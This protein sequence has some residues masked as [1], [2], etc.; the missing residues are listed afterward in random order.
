MPFNFYDVHR[1]QHKLFLD[2]KDNSWKIW[3]LFLACERSI[4]DLT[5]ILMMEH[6][7]NTLRQ[8]STYA[9]YTAKRV[10]ARTCYALQ[11]TKLF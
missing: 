3:W 4:Y 5:A 1:I 10:D 9:A 8:L 6:I 11:T 2:Q 7:I